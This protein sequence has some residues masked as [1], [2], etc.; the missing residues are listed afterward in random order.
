MSRAKRCFA[1]C[2]RP[3]AVVAVSLVLAAGAP[4]MSL[5]APPANARDEPANFVQWRPGLSSSAQPNALYLARAK[6]IGYDAVIN[7]APPQS[8]GSIATAGAIVTG[9]G[10]GYLD[11]PVDFRRPSVEEFTVFVD[12]MTQRSGQ[13]VLVHCQ[14]NMRASAFVFLYRVIHENAPVDEAVAKLTGVWI[15][16]RTWKKFIDDTLAAH[17]KKADIF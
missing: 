3:L 9:Q 12:E 5:F 7:L 15:P 14:V 4:A 17:G 11:I 16:D 13:N 10:L 2:G 8:Y 1:L 6:A